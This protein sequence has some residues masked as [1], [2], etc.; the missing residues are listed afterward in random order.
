MG[1]PRKNVTIQKQK[2]HHGWKNN[3]DDDED[4][5]DDDHDDDNGVGGEDNHRNSLMD[6]A[7]QALVACRM[8][9]LAEWQPTWHFHLVARHEILTYVG[10]LSANYPA[11]WLHCPWP[12]PLPLPFIPRRT[13]AVFSY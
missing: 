4:D 12:L 5:E 3:D 6:A 7:Q 9:R 11:A 8:N 13:L 1:N 2:L 10:H